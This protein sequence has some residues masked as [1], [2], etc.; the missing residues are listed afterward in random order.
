MA[1]QRE[2]QPAASLDSQ[3]ARA[4]AYISVTDIAPWRVSTLGPK[5]YL[6]GVTCVGPQHE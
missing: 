4:V 3:D 2:R 5:E 6:W 1:I